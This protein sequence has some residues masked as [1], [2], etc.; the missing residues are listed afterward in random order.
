MV[1]QVSEVCFE[2][3]GKI[4]CVAQDDHRRVQLRS[5]NVKRGFW[6]S[7][8]WLVLAFA[9]WGCS[10]T[11]PRTQAIDFQGSLG[12]I[13]LASE[14][15]RDPIT[16]EGDEIS[17]AKFTA[18]LPLPADLGDPG[19][20][21]LFRAG[22]VERLGR[23]PFDVDDIGASHYTAKWRISPEQLALALGPGATVSQ[24]FDAATLIDL[25]VHIPKMRW[26]PIHAMHAQIL[27]MAGANAPESGEA[28][29]I[30]EII[31]SSRIQFHFQAPM[32]QH[33]SLKGMDM[34]AAHLID[35]VYWE[36]AEKTLL[37][38]E[39]HDAV[40]ILYKTLCLDNTKGCS[41]STQAGLLRSR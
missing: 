26:R 36:D 18:P 31:S 7:L 15:V 41:A 19:T 2:Q 21:L 1:C 38:R 10:S 11:P 24:A 17:T 8:L 16:L 30:T 4:L 14:H 27:E 13:V 40:P 5:E 25:T 37:I 20:I 29:L 3:E 35:S 23:I 34:L 22:I 9:L 12:D 28:I 33:I 32:S 39:F 6:P